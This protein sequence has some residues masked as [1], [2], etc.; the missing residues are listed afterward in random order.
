MRRKIIAIAIALALAGE[1]VVYHEYGQ[2]QKHVEQPEPIIPIFTILNA[3]VITASGTANT[4]FK[5]DWIK[6]L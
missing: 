6:K 1:M 5:F 4:V 3:A 2:T